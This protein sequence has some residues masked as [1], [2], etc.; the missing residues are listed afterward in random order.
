MK[1]YIVAC[2][3]HRG[4]VKDVTLAAASEADAISYLVQ[5]GFT[6]CTVRGVAPGK[7]ADDAT[8]AV[9]ALSDPEAPPDPG[10]RNR[11]FS[12]SARPA[13]AHAADGAAR[14]RQ[15]RAGMTSDPAMSAQEPAGDEAEL[16]ADAPWW[17]TL[18]GVAR[19]L[20]LVA[21]SLARRAWRSVGA[22]FVRAA[23]G[24]RKV[25]RRNRPGG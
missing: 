10:S 24:I 18:R 5:K 11:S 15:R 1:R 12:H 2:R 22:T 16:L 7:V 8:R 14:P 19:H 21:R 13:G 6:N 4:R 25:C 3:N 20:G 9:P 17:A 23:A